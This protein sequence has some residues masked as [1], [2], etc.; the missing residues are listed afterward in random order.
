MGI[1]D[2]HVRSIGPSLCRMRPATCCMIP[3]ILCMHVLH[4]PRLLTSEPRQH[5]L[6]QIHGIGSQNVLKRTTGRF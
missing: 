1:H 3:P 5:L 2:K 6:R 4:L